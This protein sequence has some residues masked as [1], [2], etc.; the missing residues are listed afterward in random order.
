[1]LGKLFNGKLAIHT[2]R[3]RSINGPIL[4]FRP[5]IRSLA[6][7][8]DHLA[9]VTRGV[10]AHISAAMRNPRTTKPFENRGNHVA[11]DS[12]ARHQSATKPVPRGYLIIM[13]LIFRFGSGVVRA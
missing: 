4:A 3:A 13:D 9:L 8:H 7:R 10:K 5:Y 12:H 2:H 11:I 1:M 6:A